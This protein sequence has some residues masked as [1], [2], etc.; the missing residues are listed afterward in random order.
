MVCGQSFNSVYSAEAGTH[1]AQRQRLSATI[2]I[3]SVSSIG[4]RFVGGPVAPSAPLNVYRSRQMSVPM[5]RF[6]LYIISLSGAKNVGEIIMFGA[7]T[8]RKF[9]PRIFLHYNLKNHCDVKK[10]LMPFCLNKDS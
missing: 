9:R 1:S 7:T 10:H 5:L 4:Y 8:V 6:C 3:I 2:G